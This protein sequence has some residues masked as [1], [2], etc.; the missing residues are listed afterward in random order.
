MFANDSTMAIIG[1]LFYI[2]QTQLVALVK[3]AIGTKYLATVDSDNVN[4]DC[5]INTA[6]HAI[7]V[8]KI[9]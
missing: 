1:K 6:F 3:S 2:L 4:L 7:K 8:V 9:L 5:Q